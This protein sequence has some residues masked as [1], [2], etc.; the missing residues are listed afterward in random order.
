MFKTFFLSSVMFLVASVS[1][2]QTKTKGS[3]KPG[4][5]D[6]CKNHTM[7]ECRHNG[8]HKKT[9]HQV[10]IQLTS[11]DTLVW[12]ALMNNLRH[13]KEA[14]GDSVDIEVVAHGPGIDL[15]I[16]AKTTQQNDITNFKKQGIV[17]MGCENTLKARNLTKEALI[18]EAV[19][20]PSGIGEVIMKQEEGWSYLKAG[21]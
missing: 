7:K 6:C 4:E 17:F 1:Y 10:V 9:K 14:W 18:T 11:G 3:G 2:A 8:I 5:M 15:L 20:V 21:F 13:L 12:K 19:V 16:S